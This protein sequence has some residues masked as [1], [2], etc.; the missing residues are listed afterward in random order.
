MYSWFIQ[1]EEYPNEEYTCVTTQPG[2]MQ[3]TSSANSYCS[4]AFLFLAHPSPAVRQPMK[5]LSLK[6]I[7]AV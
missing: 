2:F 3:A 1:N 7:C 4:V 6:E 5:W